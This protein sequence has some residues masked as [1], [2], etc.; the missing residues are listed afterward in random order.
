MFRH[1]QSPT[2]R[3]L[4]THGEHVSLLE[5]NNNKKRRFE[6]EIVSKN[7]LPSPKPELS[8]HQHVIKRQRGINHADCQAGIIH[9]RKV[10]G[11]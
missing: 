5:K 1:I 8:Y 7:H 11:G 10:S 9:A 6:P 4:A 2:Q 3:P